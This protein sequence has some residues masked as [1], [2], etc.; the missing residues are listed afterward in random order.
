MDHSRKTG[1]L[2]SISAAVILLAAAPAYADAASRAVIIAKLKEIGT[3]AAAIF[4]AAVG[5]VAVVT[6]I[7]KVIQFFAHKIEFTK[8][9]EWGA[10]CI[11]AA[12]I[13]YVVLIFL[14]YNPITIISGI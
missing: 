13:S 11:L 10:I 7:I 3:D 1:I 4:M 14:G 6:L 9:L 5:I 12:S 2:P 8:L